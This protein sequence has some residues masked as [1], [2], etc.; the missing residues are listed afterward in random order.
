[1]TIKDAAIVVLII[2]IVFIIV[3]NRNNVRKFMNGFWRADASFAEAAGADEILLYIGEDDVAHFA[4]VGSDVEISETFSFS[5]RLPILPTLREVVATNI[6]LD[7]YNLADIWLALDVKFEF[8]VVAGFLKISS[9]DEV[10][11]LLYKDNE[12]SD[13]DF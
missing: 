9:G 8:D 10:L 1:M 6:R 5:P 2:I 12:V 13:I 7:N 3:R 4:V 11:A